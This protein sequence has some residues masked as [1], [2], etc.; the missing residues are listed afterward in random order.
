MRRFSFLR[1]ALLM[2][3]VAVVEDEDY[4]IYQ[5]G[6]CPYVDEAYDCKIN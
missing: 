6:S 2:E 3:G 5:P 4:P 1:Y